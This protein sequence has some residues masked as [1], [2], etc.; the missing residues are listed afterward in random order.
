MPS[1]VNWIADLERLNATVLAYNDEYQR[2]RMRSLMAVDEVVGTVVKRL[3]DT[4]VIYNTFIIYSTDNGFHISQ[5]RLHPGKMCG[6]ETDINIPLVIRGPGIKAGGVQVRPSTQTDLA[7]IIMQLAGNT[8]DDKQFDGTPMALGISGEKRSL[9]TEHASIEILG[10]GLTES[11][12][13]SDYNGPF[14][15]VNNTYKGLRIEAEEYGFYYSVWCNNARELYDMKACFL[16]KKIERDGEAD[17][18]SLDRSCTGQQSSGSCS[19]KTGPVEFRTPRAN[20]RH[21]PG[22]SRRTHDDT[23]VL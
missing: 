10:I 3:E 23:Q 2:L 1:S 14:Q 21:P 11:K 9:R 19:D 4:G 18:V 12:Y 5:H 8:I 13:A 22:P 7:P 17:A 16:V 20:S 6:V 15:Y